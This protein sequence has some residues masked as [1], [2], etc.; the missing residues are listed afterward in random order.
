MLGKEMFIISHG[1]FHRIVRIKRQTNDF[2]LP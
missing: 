2:S 1:I